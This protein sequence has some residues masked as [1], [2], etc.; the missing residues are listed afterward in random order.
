MGVVVAGEQFDM[1]SEEGMEV[2]R[3]DFTGRFAHTQPEEAR[4]E[5][6]VEETG[7]R[8]RR[9]RVKHPRNRLWSQFLELGAG[10]G[11]IMRRW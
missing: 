11:A 4:Q 5:D 6:Q 9:V 8:L 3:A 2:E 10:A 1:G 7:E